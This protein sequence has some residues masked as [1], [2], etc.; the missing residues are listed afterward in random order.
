M[1]AMQQFD[2]LYGFYRL[3]LEIRKILIT[4][5]ILMFIDKQPQSERRDVFN[6]GGNVCATL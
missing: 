1:I 5:K 4:Q 2:L 3:I 6:V